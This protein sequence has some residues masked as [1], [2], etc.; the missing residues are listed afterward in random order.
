M[1]QA[2]T[3]FEHD[4]E[5]NS[6]PGA[7]KPVYEV[8]DRGVQYLLSQNEGNSEPVYDTPPQKKYQ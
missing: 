2:Q 6:L 5:V 4:G 8:E 3:T 7:T 1:N